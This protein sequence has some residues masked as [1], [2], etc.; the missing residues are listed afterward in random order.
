PPPAGPPARAVGGGRSPAGGSPPTPSPSRPLLPEVAAGIPEP[1]RIAVSLF[2]A[3]PPT[4][5][6]ATGEVDELDPAAA[7]VGALRLIGKFRILDTTDGGFCEYQVNHINTLVSIADDMSTAR[8]SK[9]ADRREE[10]IMNMTTRWTSLI[11]RLPLIR[12]GWDEGQ[13][14]CW[15]G[16]R[17]WCTKLSVCT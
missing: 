11:P 16:H 9:P 1:R 13:I 15:Y 14:W 8:A 4:V 7:G 2:D 12:P 17:M 10:E 6:H 5:R 3:L